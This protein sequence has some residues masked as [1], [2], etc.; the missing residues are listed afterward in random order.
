MT[1]AEIKE[2]VD[3]YLGI[4]LDALSEKQFIDDYHRMYPIDMDLDVLAH[5]CP[6][7]YPFWC[8]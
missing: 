7:V 6:E 5:I 1:E 3:N 8:R 2:H 4:L